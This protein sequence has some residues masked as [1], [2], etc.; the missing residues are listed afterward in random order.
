[1]SAYVGAIRRSVSGPLRKGYPHARTHARTH[2]QSPVALV[3]RLRSCEFE[4][5]QR[6]C[7]V[8]LGKINPSFKFGTGRPVPGITENM[9]T[10]M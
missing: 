10:R 1:M 2:A 4:P 6:H 5:H 9:L 8:S 7:V 3:S